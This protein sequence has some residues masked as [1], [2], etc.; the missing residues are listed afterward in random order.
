MNIVK[1]KCKI[2][3]IGSSDKKD[4][5]IPTLTL[6]IGINKVNIVIISINAYYWAFK[7]KKAQVFVVFMSDL[8]F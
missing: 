8:E 4:L 6:I 5:T 1:Q 3:I 7:L 2:V